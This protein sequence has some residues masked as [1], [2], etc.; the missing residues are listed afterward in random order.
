M[1]E[2]SKLRKLTPRR[3]SPPIEAAKRFMDTDKTKL[4]KNRIVRFFKIFL[5]EGF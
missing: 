1:N 3:L 4:P 2:Q 5:G